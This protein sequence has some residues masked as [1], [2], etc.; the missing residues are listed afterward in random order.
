MHKKQA[1]II[2]TVPK[3]ARGTV[4]DSP[5]RQDPNLLLSYSYRCTALVSS[6]QYLLTCQSGPIGDKTFHFSSRQT[7]DARKKIKIKIKSALCW[8]ILCYIGTLSSPVRKTIHV[9]V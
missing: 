9:L 3:R 5:T 6:L 8:G 7:L 2:L 4:P 1:T